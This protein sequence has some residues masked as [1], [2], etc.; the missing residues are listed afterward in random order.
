VG[1]SCVLIAVFVAGLV[2]IEDGHFFLF[3]FLLAAD[4]V[5]LAALCA[6]LIG[7]VAEVTA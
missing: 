3:V 7:V 2:L 5:V 6:F 4:V 1:Q